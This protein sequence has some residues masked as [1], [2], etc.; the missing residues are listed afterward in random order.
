MTTT[1][2]TDDPRQRSGRRGFLIYLAIAATV[3]L[4]LSLYYIAKAKAFAFY[5]IG[6]DT[7]LCFYPLQVAVARQLQHLHAITWSFELG[8]G[9]F[10]GT[11]FDP[12]WL[13]TGWLPD[14][15]Q[16][17]LR[18]PMFVLR[19]LLAGGFFYAYLRETGFLV[20]VA[21]IGGL[22]YAFSSY[23]LINAQWEVMH[24]TEFVQ[25]SAYL[26]L[27]E[28]YLHDGRRWGAIAAG[29]VVGIGHPFGLYMFALFS[30]AY[31]VMR[32][33]LVDAVQRRRTA[34]DGL[35]FAGWCLLGLALTAPLLLPA[36]YY[37][38]ESPRVSGQ[39][40]IFHD[41][42]NMTASLN[43]LP[44]IGSQIAGLL[45]KDLIG[46]PDDYAGWHNYFEGPGF[47]AGLLPLLG[48]AQLLG[49][50][51]VRRER[52]LLLAGVAGCAL[53]FAWPALRY[54]V[55]AF[56]HVTFRFSTLWI[57]AL[58]LVL[59]LLGLQR[60][61]SS[62]WWRPGLAIG[63][64]AILA[65]VIATAILAP[66]ALNVEHAV[67]V[68]GFV[69]LYVALALLTTTAGGRPWSIG[70]VFVAICACELLAFATPAVVGRGAVN[71]DGSGP[72][73][74]Y[75]DDTVKAL[76]YI[77]EH[78]QDNAFFRVEKTYSSLF[79]DD[80]LVQGYAG[81]ASYYFHA[82]SLTRFVDRMGLPR[83]TQSPNYI[84]PM[85]PRMQ[86]LD[87]LGVRYVLTRKRSL[88]RVPDMIHVATTGDVDIYR[89]E[90]ARPFA[91]FYDTIAS[92]NQADA[93][94]PG[95]RDGFLLT[96]A[97]VEDVDGVNAALAALRE[98][99]DPAP[100]PRQTFVAKPRDDQLSGEV[101]TPVAS[102][103]LL[104]MPF[105][106]GWRAWLDDKDVELFRADY[107]LTALLVPAG[108]HRLALRYAPP[109]RALGFSLMAGAI[110][111]LVVFELLSTASAPRSPAARAGRLFERLRT[112]RRS[113]GRATIP[114]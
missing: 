88:D 62:G 99:G 84:A 95:M 23:G 15:S 97:I 21:I 46:K 105:D 72:S 82:S 35:R 90:A 37:L 68:I 111:F 77:R 49:P 47:Y 39:Y 45:G 79:E 94:P 52:L 8:L 43:D 81:T 53:Y 71:A 86:V 18:L 98:A 50:R 5:D 70:Y 107:G 73:G 38:L 12:L 67:R 51:A 108:A 48:I 76:A 78:P 60:A 17:S 87:L 91:T 75:D 24:G 93:Q 57:S 59:G 56:G 32:L 58:L 27:L 55:Y 4:T 100:L 80:A 114:G 85:T 25:F 13:I 1:L 104:S 19:L 20:P 44:T 3:A 66:V 14:A 7:L 65:I 89:N 101:Q 61:L 96:S 109:G 110:A 33:L 30:L 103:L 22:G 63:A 36:L 41:A 11:L 69:G 64:S 42:V 26:F 92:E 31:G 2:V 6:S 112:R 9:G 106:R 29:A 10:L 54:A 34:L 113:T 40:S 83:A 28:R 74:R 102:L 16:L